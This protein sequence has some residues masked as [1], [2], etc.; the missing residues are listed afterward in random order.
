[1]TSR[2]RQLRGAAR[3]SQQ[4]LA[5]AV[6]TTK[7]QISKLENSQRSLKEAWMRR[8]APALGVEPV[9]FLREPPRPSVSDVEIYCGALPHDLENIITGIVAMLRAGPSSYPTALVNIRHLVDTIEGKVAASH[10][11]NKSDPIRASKR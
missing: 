10:S 3:L 9:E 5:D 11:D 8:L 1:M 4:E 2:L 6:G 7:Q